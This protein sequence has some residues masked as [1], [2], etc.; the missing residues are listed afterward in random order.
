MA[1]VDLNRVS[2]TRGSLL[3]LA[4]QTDKTS[5]EELLYDPVF[6]EHFLYFLECEHSEENLYFVK[7][8]ELYSKSS[9]GGSAKEFDI[10]K[11]AF[12]IY[13]LYIQPN[14][15]K[16]VNISATI[17]KEI[18]TKINEGNFAVDLFKKARNCVLV[19]M[20]GDPYFRFL[21]SK[22]YLEMKDTKPRT[23][24]RRNSIIDNKTASAAALTDFLSERPEL[25]ELVNKNILISNK[26]RRSSKLETRW[27]L[28]SMLDQH[29]R[30]KK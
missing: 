8:I 3:K 25:Q 26:E 16:E 14:A 7:D 11:E 23:R 20:E 17:R 19:L 6:T 1:Q 29:S 21:S 5:L 27:T 13:E 30:S 10:K 9:M 24:E 2:G 18:E 22:E 4:S 15:K 28:S 12:R